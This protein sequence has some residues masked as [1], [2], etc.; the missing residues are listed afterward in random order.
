MQMIC[1]NHDFEWQIFVTLDVKGFI[2]LANYFNFF[3]LEKKCIYL[4]FC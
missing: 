1:F 3:S 4:H 2:F